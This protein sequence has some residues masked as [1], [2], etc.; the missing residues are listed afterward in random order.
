[1]GAIENK[2]LIRSMWAEAAKGNVEVILNSYADDV[3]YTII[4]TTKFSGTFSGKQDVVNRLF[5]PLF[6]QLVAGIAITP[7]NLIA[8]GEF[9][10]MQ[11]HG[12]AKS[13]SGADYNN[14]YCFV[15]R[16]QGGKIK[17]ITEYLDSELVTRVFGK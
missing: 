11:A 1:M 12:E 5:T 4:G 6:A 14:T 8:D 16:V 3:R 9:V 2:E 7:D 13:K 10:A 17:E 15:F